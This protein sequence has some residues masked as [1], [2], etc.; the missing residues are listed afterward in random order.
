MKH[1]FSNSI[2][3][4]PLLFVLSLHA[5]ETSLQLLGPREGDPASIIE[6]VSTIHGDY[7]ELEVDLIVPG[8]DPL[9]LSRFY[10]SHDTPASAHFGGWRF[11]PKCI[12]WIDK[13]PKGKTYSTPEGKFDRSYV[14]V[15]TDEG[16][17]LTYIGWQNTTNPRAKSLYTVDIDG[18]IFNLTNTARGAPHSWTNQKNNQLYSQEDRFELILANLGKRDYVK[19][20]SKDFYLLEKETLPSGNKIFYEY[21]R[22]GRP[23]LIKMMSAKEEKVLSWIKIRYGQTTSVETSDKKTAL[24]H[25]DE[26]SS[27]RPL[28]TKVSSAH[29]PSVTYQYQSTG[30][31]P[32]IIRKELSGGQEVQIEYLADSSGK[33][34][35]HSI[36][37]ALSDSL[38]ARRE[39]TYYFDNDGSG[40]TEIH[41]P[42]EERMTHS[43]NG[44]LQLTSIEEYL[45]GALYRVQRKLWGMKKDACSLLQSSV[46]DSSG[47]V[48]YAKAF[49][50]DDYGR[51]L[52][53]KEYG[54]LTG[55]HPDPL[56]LNTDGTV[57]DSQEGHVKTYSYIQADGFD[58]VNQ[59]DAKGSGIRYCYS[60]GTNLLVKKYILAKDKRKKRWFYDY[61]AEGTLTQVLIDDG[62]ESTPKSTWYLG[63]R[64]I[65]IIVPKQE[66]PAIGAPEVIEEKYLDTKTK[67]EVLVKKTVNHFDSFGNI[68]LQEIYDANGEHRYTLIK[69]YENGLLTMETDAKGNETHYTYDAAHNLVE[70]ANMATG[71]SVQYGY[72]LEN[73]LI[74]RAEQSNG[75]TLETK[76]SYNASGHKVSE[77]DRFGNET[78]YVVDSLGRTKTVTYPE[79]ATENGGTLTPTYAYEYDLFNHVTQVTDP[80]GAITSK[81]NTPT[82]NPIRIQHPDGFEELFK[83]DFEGSLHRHLGRDGLVKVFEYDYMGRLNHI[84]YYERGSK[85]SRDGF[86]REY[87]DYNAF[88]MTSEK[89]EEGNRTTYSYDGA[90]RLISLKKDAQKVEFFHDALGKVSGFKR[91]KSKDTFTYIQKEYDLLGNVIFETTEDETGKLLTKS[92]YAYD[93]AG[94][95]TEI[96]GYPNHNK[97]SLKRFE[98]DSFGR[99]TKEIDAQ[100]FACEV[101]YDEGFI[102][103]WGKRNLKK[104]TID[105]L[106]NSI[107]EIY[108]LA[109]NLVSNNKKDKSGKL[110]SSS[111]FFHDVFGLETSRIDAVIDSKEKTKVY[112]SRRAYIP[113]HHLGEMHI[114]ATSPEEK[115]IQL[116]YNLYGDLKTKLEP[117]APSPVSYEYNN[118]GDLE[119]ILFQAKEF[120]KETVCK[121]RYDKKGNLVN[122]TESA[123]RSLSR[124]Y[125]AHDQLTEETIKDDYGS[126]SVKCSY[127]GEGCITQITLPDGSFIEYDYEG[128]FVKKAARY[129]KEK[130][131]LYQYKIFSRDLMGNILEEIFPYHAGSRKHR[132][133]KSGRRV[134]VATDFF[135]DTAQGYDPLGNLTLRETLLDGEKSTTS[136][137]YDALS[138][139]LSEKGENEHTYL[140]DSIGN[141]L[142]KDDIHYTVNG[143]NQI[144]ETERGTYTFDAR[145]NLK[146]KNINGRTWEFKHNPLNQLISIIL[147]NGSMVTFTYDVAG[148]RLSKKVEAGRKTEVFRYFY[149]GQTELG[150][151]DTK[152]NIVQLRV[153]SD[154]NQAEK[155]PFIA[156][157]LQKEV[158]VPIYD[159]QDNVAMLVDP[160]KR[161]IQESYRYSVFGEEE[162]INRRGR[163][164]ACSPTQNPW[165]YRGE[166]TDEETSLLCIGYRYYDP[167]I[168]RWIDPDPAG[169]LDGPNLYAYCRNNPLTY[170]DYF[171]L[172]SEKSSVDESYFY[173]EY[174]PHCYCE[175]HRNCKRGG[176][177]QANQRLSSGLSI[178][179][180]YDLSL[181]VLSHPRVQGSMQAFVG[182]AEASAGGLATLGSGGLAA[183]IGLPVLI[184]GLDQF[185]AGMNTA[186]TGQHRATLTEQLLQT[187]GMSPEWASFTNDVLSIGGTLGGAAIIR[188]SR[189]RTF[190]NFQL[191]ATPKLSSNISESPLKNTRY[192]KKVLAQMERNLKTGQTDFHGFPRTVDNYAGLGKKELIQGRD[193]LTRMKVTVKGAYKGKSGIFE[194]IVEADGSINHR[195]FIPN[196]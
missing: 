124:K 82:G 5:N 46:E 111:R 157:E 53:E 174:E 159:I 179:S 38:I 120:E 126:Y 191:G 153:P 43:Y 15:G 101:H 89:D 168:G 160:E 78:L 48:Y 72:D 161:I 34:R 52:T 140:Y 27:H 84:E 94:R 141:R 8:P 22:E 184:H 133:D 10:S 70:E 37:K 12:L 73:R 181:E 60:Q 176:D 45:N 172:A 91:W 55:A 142:S 96:I 137:T 129:S 151:L 7:S 148:K 87:F 35:V 189:I 49:S 152:G 93:D 145:G 163:T 54:N 79:I 64:L 44:D 90:G 36:T 51:V 180:A 178:G 155:G 134:E 165:R 102:N 154:P 128:P 92:E 85:G 130:K 29:K 76:I 71:I 109:G 144:I 183:P 107:E 1:F 4:L 143:A 50:Y 11:L 2:F 30:T 162:I 33:N 69:R 158:Y 177:I 31:H 196:L 97:S 156:F 132:F 19:H 147:P 136:Y 171:G 65:T 20:P 127:D 170:I 195:I 58:V 166:H 138:Q 75:H 41:G 67:Q 25:F 77:T 146:E 114:A 185:I 188:A 139:L 13:D 68:T 164:V 150:C 112:Q 40:Y 18:K 57:H 123:N 187:S 122:F 39:F 116:T 88:H 100:G 167:E 182:F 66:F 74:Y 117:K 186:I 110:L 80:Y 16:S 115:V 190:P 3:L 61:N 14:R 81:V 113:G 192:T 193:G 47:A 131:E 173:G 42:T 32:L 194:W 59:I 17:I 6:G 98:Y 149:L 24:Y 9:V 103:E 125:N 86:K 62:D 83:Y 99:L 104:T 23:I 63:K 108:D 95:L 135:Q 119:K 105:P 121:F 28:L 56:V 175:R 118:R 26:D 106:G 21:D 169:D